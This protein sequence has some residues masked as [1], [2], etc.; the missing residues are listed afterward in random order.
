VADAEEFSTALSRIT[1]MLDHNQIARDTPPR[2][3]TP[4]S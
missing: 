1:R 2:W 3:P 4:W